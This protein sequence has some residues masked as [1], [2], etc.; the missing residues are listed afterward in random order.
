MVDYPHKFGN[1]YN[2]PL[3]YC[4]FAFQVKPSLP[5]IKEQLLAGNRPKGDN[6]AQI[7]TVKVTFS[8]TKLKQTYNTGIRER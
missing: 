8:L 7:K 1:L 6:K 3:P 4:V 5:S 2:L